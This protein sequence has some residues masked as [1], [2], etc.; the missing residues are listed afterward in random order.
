VIKARRMRWAGHVAV[1]VGH[2]TNTMQ[3]I[4]PKAY[5]SENKSFLAPMIK[6]K[7]HNIF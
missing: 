5:L 1:L 2:I 7:G 6:Y 4:W 3:A